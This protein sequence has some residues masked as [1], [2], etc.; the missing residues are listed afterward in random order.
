MGGHKLYAAIPPLDCTCPGSY[1]PQ[2]FGGQYCSQNFQAAS[3][4]RGHTFVDESQEQLRGQLAHRKLLGLIEDRLRAWAA[5]RNSGASKAGHRGLDG[6]L[7]LPQI[8]VELGLSQSLR[9]RHK[10]QRAVAMLVVVPVREAVH[11][12]PGLLQ[13]VEGPLRPQRTLLR[14]SER[15]P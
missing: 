1:L 7:Q 12:V 13:R 9:R 2:R 14:R 10:L 15:M 11:P 8:A 5:F 4:S 3:A 6:F